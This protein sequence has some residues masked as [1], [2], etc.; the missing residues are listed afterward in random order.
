MSESTRSGRRYGCLFLLA[1]MAVTAI[2][3]VLAIK[4][5]AS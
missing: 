4:G 1:V 2:G 5:V 3:I